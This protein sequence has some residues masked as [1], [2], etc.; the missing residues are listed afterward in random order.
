MV[1]YHDFPHWDE[2]PFVMLPSLRDLLTY[3]TNG[4]KVVGIIAIATYL[5]EGIVV[6]A[7]SLYRSL[8][9]SW[10]HMRGASSD[11]APNEEEDL[12]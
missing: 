12:S 9:R 2:L 5:L 4:E 3:L 6:V 10:K 1:F 11:S 8:Q 7:L